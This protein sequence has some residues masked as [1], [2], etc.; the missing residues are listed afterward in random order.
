[1]VIVGAGAVGKILA[2][3]LHMPPGNV[4]HIAEEKEDKSVLRQEKKFIIKAAPAMYGWRP[5]LSRAERR[6]QERKSFKINKKL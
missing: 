2:D 1:M 3:V 6:K 4:V 5:P